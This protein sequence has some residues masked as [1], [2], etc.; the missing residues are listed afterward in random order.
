M[1]FVSMIMRMTRKMIWVWC[2]LTPILVFFLIDKNLGG[3]LLSIG[4]VAIIIYEDK[5]Y[6][7]KKEKNE[8]QNNKQII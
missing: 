4:I 6:N 8:E 7:M 2:L 3:A 5:I 1:S